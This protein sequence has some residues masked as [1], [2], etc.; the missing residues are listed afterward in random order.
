MELFMKFTQHISL[1]ISASSANASNWNYSNSVEYMNAKIK[2]TTISPSIQ[3]HTAFSNFGFYNR[4]RMFTAVSPVVGF[5]DLTLA[6]P[7]FDIQSSNGTILPPVN[8]VNFYYGIKGD[9]GLE[10]AFSQS[11]GFVISY[12]YQYSWV[13]SALYN[14]NHFAISQINIGILLKLKKDKRF[15]YR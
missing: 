10:Y 8:S 9:I 7:L 2:M 6:N 12:T 1:G 13:T 14:D 5:S 4:A 15:I 3:C 11:F